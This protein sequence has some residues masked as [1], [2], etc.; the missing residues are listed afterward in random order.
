M[1]NILS[2]SYGLSGTPLQND[3]GGGGTVLV[4]NV[5]RKTTVSDVSGETWEQPLSVT[6]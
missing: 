1:S 5:Q 4:S 6:Y 3:P 2:M